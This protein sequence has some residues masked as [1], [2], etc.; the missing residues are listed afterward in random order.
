L[1]RLIEYARPATEQCAPIAPNS[2]ASDEQS[3]Y[4]PVGEHILDVELA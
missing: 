1:A 4:A 3:P 2:E